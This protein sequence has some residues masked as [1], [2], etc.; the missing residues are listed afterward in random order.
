MIFKRRNLNPMNPNLKKVR[1]L[2]KRR[3]KSSGMKYSDL[4][5]LSGFSELK[6]R[7]YMSNQDF[8]F[9]DL[10]LILESLKMGI[11]TELKGDFGL[12][13]QMKP[14][15]LA[16]EKLLTE[17]PQ[18]GLFFLKIRFGSPISK[19][20]KIAGIDESQRSRVLRKLEKVGLLEYMPGDRTLIKTNSPSLYLKNGPIL[21]VQVPLFIE[22]LFEHFRKHSKELY[23]GY[24]FKK[25]SQSIL[26]PFEFYLDESINKQFCQELF[27]LVSKYREI[28]VSLDREK[29]SLFPVSGII[30]SD[31]NDA[32]KNVYDVLIDRSK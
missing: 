21:K 9:K 3:L 4:A 23:S 20:L 19:A 12:K 16:Q 28:S 2:I 22:Q 17:N 30:A 13:Y 1:D 25:E 32:W 7:R 10:I 29:N 14:Y 26:I 18:I 8:K 31:I 6:I 24:E 27:S 11:F 15:T 5:K